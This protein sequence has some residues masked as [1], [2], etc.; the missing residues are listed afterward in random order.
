[1][2]R[3]TMDIDL[4][5]E[6]GSDHVNALVARLLADYYVD[7]EMIR[8]APAQGGLR[9]P[10]VAR[11]RVDRAAQDVDGCSFDRHTL[12]DGGG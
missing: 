10:D 4:V 2:A 9:V 3:A 6:L 12:I 8:E 5:A 1:M 11:T 7:A